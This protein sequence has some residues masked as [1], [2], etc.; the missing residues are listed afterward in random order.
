[1]FPDLG[2]TQAQAAVIVGFFLPLILAIPIQSHWP[3]EVKT[4]FSV[5]AYAA[6]GAV[7]AAATGNLTG[8]TFWQTT[9]EILVLGVVGYQGVWKP[10]NL[11]PTIAA[12]TDVANPTPTADNGTPATKAVDGASAP[13]ASNEAS[14]GVSGSG[15]SSGDAPGVSPGQP[16]TPTLEQLLAAGTRLVEELTNG[17]YANRTGNGAVTKPVTPEEP[18]AERESK[19]NAG[20]PDAS[21]PEKSAAAWVAA[22]RTS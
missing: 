8:K 15:K 7:T 5:A 10:S 17:F 3:T 20:K 12:R 21:D 2:S 14:A 19:P 9:L 18:D 16:M 1:M 11:A 4:L 6:A 13:A 22:G